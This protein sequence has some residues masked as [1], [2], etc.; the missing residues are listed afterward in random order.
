MKFD[1]LVKIVIDTDSAKEARMLVESELEENVRFSDFIIE[2]VR[3]H[4][5]DDDEDDDEGEPEDD[6][7]L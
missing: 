1:V 4:E 6:L 7:D 5:N 2:K 3:V